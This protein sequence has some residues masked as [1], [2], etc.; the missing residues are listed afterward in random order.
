MSCHHCHK[1]LAAKSYVLSIAA[2]KVVSAD[3]AVM[4]DE[5]DMPVT[6]SADISFHDH[7]LTELSGTASVDLLDGIDTS[8]AQAEA[9]FC[10]KRCLTDWFAGK[11]NSLTDLSA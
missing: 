7:G 6:L 5:A 8:H 4:V 9:C 10:S 11:V 2:M 3:R 1:P